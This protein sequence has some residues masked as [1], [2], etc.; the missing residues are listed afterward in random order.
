[1]LLL[2]LTACPSNSI[3]SVGITPKTVSVT[4]F[5]TQQFTATVFGM[6]N[7][8][9]S[10]SASA[11]SI[12]SSGLLTAPSSGMVKV[13]ATSVQD[14]SK[15]DLAV[16]TILLPNVSISL[17]VP[18]SLESAGVA[19]MV[20]TVTGS[21]NT[22]V[23]WSTTAGTISMAGLFTPPDATTSVTITATSAANPNI[24]QTAQIAVVKSG[25]LNGNLFFDQ[26]KNGI[27]DSTDTPRGG[28]LVWLDDNTNAIADPNERQAYTDASGNYVLTRV[29]SGR[30]NVRHE[31]PLGYGSSLAASNS[32]LTPQIVGGTTAPSGKWNAIVALLSSNRADPY[33]AQFCGGSLVAP[34]WVLT[35]AHCL[36][37]K[38]GAVVSTASLN[39]GI[40]FTSLAGTV[41]RVA[42]G[43]IIVHPSYNP[44]SDDN[45]LALLRL[46]SQS[47][48]N[49]VRPILPSETALSAAGVTGLIVG[50]GN[51][52]ATDILY[53][54][55]LQ[56]ASVPVIDQQTC[57][58]QLLPLG[59]TGNMLC[60]AYP[61]G[62]VDSCQGDS[63]G[64]M[65]VQNLGVLRQ[66]GIVSWGV[67]CAK[68]G[69]PGVYTRISNYDAWLASNLGRVAPP[70]TSITLAI[71]ETKTQN[72]AVR[73]P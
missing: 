35:A 12:D 67:G 45:D 16:V 50:W 5:T 34:N 53:P 69:K 1:M 43:Q 47:T 49:T 39:V 24:S 18:S 48:K 15:S 70:N 7:L 19:T 46:S 37:D 30:R 52:S 59:L 36:F 73:T 56:E 71:G 14:S 63:G 4:A 3:Q 72:F 29:K 8:A 11:G 17:S 10:W 33:A 28:W 64:P 42:V 38:D 60:A 32:R 22:S 68:A 61:D 51:I 40:G 57:A 27:K 44:I 55:E 58:S 65:Y 26:N 25:G 20:A 41:S 23:T 62:G 13:I 6:G 9:V 31:M 66:I 21:S 2:L 54:S